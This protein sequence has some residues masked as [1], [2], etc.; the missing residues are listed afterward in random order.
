MKAE[1]QRLDALLVE[2]GLAD[3]RSRAQAMILAGTVRVEGEV[4][5]KA[6]TRYSPEEGLDLCVER[7]SPFVSR[8]GEKLSVALD[9]FEVDVEGRFCMDAGASTGGFTDVLLQRGAERVIAAD[10]GYGQ[11]DWRLRSDERVEVMERANVRHLSGEDLPFAPDLLVSDL[12]FIS[13]AVAL[14]RLLSSTP[15]IVEAIVLVKPQF[16]AGPKE[17]RRGG[18]VSD[19]EVREAVI[20]SV[21]E[22]F[23]RFGFGAR[24]LARAAVAGR[25]SGNQ[26]Y[27]MRLLR[28]AELSLDETRVREVVRGG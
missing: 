26:E 24:E 20:S 9:E 21:A 8:A 28:G 4:V 23:S 27:V 15:S 6:G 12:S 25:K 2:R 11:L 3:S 1:R 16:E 5:R 10:V 7:P 22:S 13:L 18:V 19:P 17:V 14:E